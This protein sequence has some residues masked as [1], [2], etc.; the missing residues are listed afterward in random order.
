VKGDVWRLLC[1]LFISCLIIDVLVTLLRAREKC[2]P[3]E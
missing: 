3:S 1:V 2:S